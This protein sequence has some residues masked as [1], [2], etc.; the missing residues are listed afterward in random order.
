M[1]PRP[2]C[3]N[4]YCGVESPPIL[5]TDE[6]NFESV[7]FFLSPAGQLNPS[8]PTISVCNVFLAG[9]SEG[10]GWCGENCEDR[11]LLSMMSVHSPPSVLSCP[12][13]H[14]LP[15]PYRLCLAA[16]YFRVNFLLE[17]ERGVAPS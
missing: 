11:W 10:T 15:F 2:S 7:I 6:F 16:F 4:V 3:L 14:F 1:A 5:E 8:P 13:L 17:T 12:F 9:P